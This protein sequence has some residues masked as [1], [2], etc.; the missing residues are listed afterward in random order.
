M[1]KHEAKSSIST[2]IIKVFVLKTNSI[3]FPLRFNSSTTQLEM[4]SLGIS[5]PQHYDSY[6]SIKF[7]VCQN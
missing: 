5:Y 3:D 1:K 7:I 4:S 6:A 2:Q